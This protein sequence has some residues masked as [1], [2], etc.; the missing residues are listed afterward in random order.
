M[1][2]H[3]NLYPFPLPC[4]ETAIEIEMIDIENL[5]QSVQTNCHISDAKYAGNYSLCVFL[6][7]MREYYRWER[8]IPLSQP[9]TKSNV[10]EWLSQR[11]CEWAEYEDREFESLLIEK[12]EIDP[13]D[14]NRI[15]K[16]LN[17]HGFVYSGG[18]GVFGKP[19][20]FI[21]ELEER[22]NI[23][24]LRIYIAGKELAR[25]LV[26]PPAMIVENRIFIR[27]ESLRRFIW[28]KI[29]EWRWKSDP[30]TPMARALNYYHLG[31]DDVEL[32]LDAMVNNEASS[33]ILHE[34]GEAKATRIVG[35]EW[36]EILHGLP[37]SG[38][39]L[40]LRAIKDHLADT[41]STLP[42]L[43]ESENLPAIHFYFA[44]FTGM[45]KE[46]FPEAVTAYKKWVGN[47]NPTVLE[48]LCHSGKNRWM[49]IA[50]KIRET[51][52]RDQSVVTEHLEAIVDF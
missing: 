7:K 15:N 21:A 45:R 13:F 24:D 33:A 48:K 22:Q 1:C 46:I 4:F 30:D 34:I 49:E 12:Q 10:G 40:K 11:E 6:L 41:I 39:E 8:K 32:T 9:L 28:E 38:L 43:L 3:L 25:D 29:E 52:Q 16:I 37:H 17:S 42:G 31:H 20:F 44:N 18:Y 27:K 14:A 51:Y 26:A 23:D 50:E 19:H 35:P 5:A 2:I 36:R 47:C